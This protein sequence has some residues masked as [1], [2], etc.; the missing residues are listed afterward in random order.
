MKGS[1]LSGGSRLTAA[2]GG[3]PGPLVGL[4][5]DGGVPPPTVVGLPPAGLHPVKTDCL[6]IDI[7]VSPA[8]VTP[9]RAGLCADTGTDHRQRPSSTEPGQ[10]SAS[11]WRTCCWGSPQRRWACRALHGH[12]PAPATP[13]HP[14]DWALGK[15]QP[16][17][18]VLSAART[19]CC[20]AP[21]AACKDVNSGCFPRRQ[22]V[23]NCRGNYDCG[24]ATTCMAAPVR[25]GCRR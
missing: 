5:G 3:E 2:G 15:R 18:C 7:V 25:S 20:T 8:V 16:P 19:A 12:A 17:P 4:L 6:Y 11:R 9:Q 21:A 24:H 14:T 22:R 13:A 23:S 10:V 1:S